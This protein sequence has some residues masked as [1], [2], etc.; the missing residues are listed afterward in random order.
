MIDPNG[1]SGRPLLLDTMS[2]HPC[3]L[4]LPHKGWQVDYADRVLGRSGGTSPADRQITLLFL[5]WRTTPR[6]SFFS[7]NLESGGV[8]S[9]PDAILQ[10][11]LSFELLK[12]LGGEMSRSAG[13]G[14]GDERGRVGSV[15]FESNGE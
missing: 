2:A 4:E 3:C 1:T 6:P 13:D 7:M 10:A 9:P 15:G 12:V 5:K 14:A 8:T 11:R